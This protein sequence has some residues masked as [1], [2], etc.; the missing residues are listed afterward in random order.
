MW[1]RYKM[2]EEKPDKTLMFRSFFSTCF[3]VQGNMS[4]KAM[5]YLTNL[6]N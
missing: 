2:P 4:Q 1:V 3:R 5:N 6:F